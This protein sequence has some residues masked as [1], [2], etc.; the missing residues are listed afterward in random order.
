MST[1]MYING[2]AVGNGNWKLKSVQNYST[3][4]NIEIKD[5]YSITAT[6]D[7]AYT[8]FLDLK[9]GKYN[10]GDATDHYGRAGL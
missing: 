1:T 4:K 2:K 9:T 3:K 7:Y 8:S 5:A 10:D 6:C